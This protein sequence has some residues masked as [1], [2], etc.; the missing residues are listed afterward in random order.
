M[1]NSITQ[2]YDV[3]V[4]WSE[5]LLALTVIV[6]VLVYAATSV[7]VFVGMDWG[8]NE[9]IYDLIYRVL[10]V[11]IGLELARMLVTHDLKTILEVLAFVVARKMLKPDLTAVDIGIS[12]VAFVALVM[13]NRYGF[14]ASADHRDVAAKEQPVP[15]PEVP[16]K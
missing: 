3:L 10:L 2:Y 12:V 16:K 1:K 14:P 13:A 11:V 15:P 8:E 6:G 5:R 9:T 4:K 7:P